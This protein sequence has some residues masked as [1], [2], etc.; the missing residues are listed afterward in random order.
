MLLYRCISN[1]STLSCCNRC[2]ITVFMMV[3]KHLLDTNIEILKLISR[4]I[5]FSLLTKIKKLCAKEKIQLILRRQY[6]FADDIPA[7][8]D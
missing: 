1:L 3:I 4:V 2:F 8:F 5:S 6:V 7:V